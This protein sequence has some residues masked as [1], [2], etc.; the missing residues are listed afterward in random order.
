MRQA[1]FSEY[2]YRFPIMMKYGGWESQIVRQLY[3]NAIR[4]LYGIGG[5]MIQLV[6]ALG[7]VIAIICSAGPLVAQNTSNAGA[8]E[9]P[10]NILRYHVSPA[11]M[12]ASI[13][14]VSNGSVTS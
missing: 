1:D 3:V 6:R 13:R 2:E 14:D 10:E 9:V 5:E 8:S 11:G 4:F 7:A 12:R